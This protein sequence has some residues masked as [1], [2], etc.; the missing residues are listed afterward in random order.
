MTKAFSRVIIL[1]NKKKKG[2][3]DMGIDEEKIC[4]GLLEKC[5]ERE[6]KYFQNIRMGMRLNPNSKQI[7]STTSSE[8]VLLRLQYKKYT[9]MIK[10]AFDILE[11]NFSLWKA[12]DLIEEEEMNLGSKNDFWASDYIAFR[13]KVILFKEV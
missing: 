4:Q 12:W 13:C 5:L 7:L 9:E 8:C 11:K 3:G 10:W 2:D 6:N 1:G